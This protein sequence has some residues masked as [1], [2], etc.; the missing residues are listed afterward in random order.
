MTERADAMSLDRGDQPSRE[1][2]MNYVRQ[3]RLGTTALVDLP[4]AAEPPRGRTTNDGIRRIDSRTV[5]SGCAVLLGLVGVWVTMRALDLQPPSACRALPVPL[6]FGAETATRIETGSGTACT[7]SVQPGT[8]MIED[9][10]VT[11]AAQHGSISPRGRT[12]VIYR[13]H[14][15]YR[16]EDDFALALR[17]RADSS[18]GVAIIRVRIDVR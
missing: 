14:G 5:L 16:G 12:G 15:N 9:L 18:A 7:V 13:A 6:T 8:A 2:T 11:S 17:G 10:T 1:L 3:A 4:P